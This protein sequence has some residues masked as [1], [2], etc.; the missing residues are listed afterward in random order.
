MTRTEAYTRYR[1][2]P[3]GQRQRRWEEY[4]RATAEQLAREVE[5]EPELP[6]GER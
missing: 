5:P 4:R 1:T 3:K 2:A 6:L